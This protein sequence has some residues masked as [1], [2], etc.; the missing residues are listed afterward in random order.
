MCYKFVETK[1]SIA[2]AEAH[3]TLASVHDETTN[4]FLKNLAGGQKY[5]LGA[6]RMSADSKVFRWV[7][8]SGTTADYSNW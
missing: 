7:D 2:D 6:R 4:D 8:G 1:L 5:W 3:C